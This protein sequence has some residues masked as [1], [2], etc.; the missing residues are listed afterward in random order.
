MELIEN[1]KVQIQ[2]LQHLEGE[3]DKLKKENTKLILND[4]TLQH[5]MDDQKK[6]IGINREN[7][8][9]AAKSEK[10]PNDSDVKLKKENTK[11]IINDKTLQRKMDDQKKQIGINRE[12]TPS[13]ATSENEPNDSAVT[14]KESSS[15]VLEAESSLPSAELSFSARAQVTD[16]NYRLSKVSAIHSVPA[17]TVFL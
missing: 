9:S 12:N 13:A 1:L 10:E 14:G 3:N 16:E 2:Q 7:K 15:S 11:L 4:K 5:K 8:T 6:Q 17:C